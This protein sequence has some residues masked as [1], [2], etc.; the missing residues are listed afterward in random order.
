M[1]NEIGRST[2]VDPSAADF[3]GYNL[4]TGSQ[5]K[6][7]G[8][9]PHCY[10]PRHSQGTYVC[11]RERHSKFIAAHATRFTELDSND[12]ISEQKK[13]ITIEN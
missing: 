6:E 13:T 8:D 5:F 7:G 4:K 10:L 3:N 11:Y 12:V 9:A 2:R 1:G